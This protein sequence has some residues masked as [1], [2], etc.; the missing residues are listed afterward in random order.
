MMCYDCATFKKSATTFWKPLPKE[1]LGTVMHSGFCYANG[2]SYKRRSEIELEFYGK[3]TDWENAEHFPK[4]S[5]SV[6]SKLKIIF[7]NIGSGIRKA[8]NRL[9]RAKVP[10]RDSYTDA[11]FPLSSSDLVEAPW[12]SLKKDVKWKR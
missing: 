6:M 8:L 1:V 7:A 3:A 10:L 5:V 4:Q 12:V 9:N 11:P 2:V